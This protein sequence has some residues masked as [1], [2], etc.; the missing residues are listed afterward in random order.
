MCTGSR[1][2]SSIGSTVSSTGYVVRVPECATKKRDNSLSVTDL[3]K[4]MYCL[5]LKSRYSGDFCNSYIPV[6][7]HP[8]MCSIKYIL[9][10]NKTYI[11]NGF[12]GIPLY[13]K[14]QYTVKQPVWMSDLVTG[15]QTTKTG[16][17]N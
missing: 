4:Y 7:L 8:N 11:Q 3:Y 6:T 16:L 15:K 2:S 1:T 9:M 14:G 10:Y 17:D 5:Y 13:L 12:H